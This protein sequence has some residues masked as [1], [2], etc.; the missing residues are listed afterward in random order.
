MLVY[1]QKLYFPYLNLGGGDLNERELNRVH[2]M[3]TPGDSN[4]RGL[5]ELNS[6]QIYRNYKC[7]Q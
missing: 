1:S 2:V 5:R 4:K 7:V 6:N 3:D